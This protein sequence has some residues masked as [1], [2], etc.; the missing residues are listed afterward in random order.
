[1]KLHWSSAIRSHSSF[2]VLTTLLQ[3]LKLTFS[4]ARPPHRAP[5]GTWTPS[6]DLAFIDSEWCRLQESTSERTL[7]IFP[8]TRPQS[9]LWNIDTSN[10]RL[11][12]EIWREVALFL[13][14]RD[15]KTLL[16][17]PHVLSRIAFELVFQV[18]DL[19]LGACVAEDDAPHGDWVPEDDVLFRRDLKLEK[20]LAQRTAD[21]IARIMIDP[22]FSR[23]VRKL[24]ISASPHHRCDHMVFQTSEQLGRRPFPARAD[25][26]SQ[27]CSPLRCRS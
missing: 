15:L 16:H 9:R 3:H 14:R 13:P 23:L 7:A 2:V 12:T 8:L 25:F 24:R 21:I 22:S 18:L 11:S 6:R 1:M 17:V 20:W 10:R 19:H 4:N 5:A 27:R 26:A